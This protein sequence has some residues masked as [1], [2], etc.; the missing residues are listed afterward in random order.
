MTSQEAS[1][2]FMQT[3]DV[4]TYFINSFDDKQRIWIILTNFAKKS[5]I[6]D[7]IFYISTDLVQSKMSDQGWKE[8]QCEVTTSIFG[9]KSIFTHELPEVE[10]ENGI[11]FATDSAEDKAMFEWECGGYED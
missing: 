8:M 5:V 2:S 3:S 11:I 10:L 7:E 6:I 4:A 1:G 9:L